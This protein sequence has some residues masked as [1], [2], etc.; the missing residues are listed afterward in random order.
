MAVE[1]GQLT[2]PAHV[3]G[4]VE[5]PEDAVALFEAGLV[6][7]AEGLPTK[8]GPRYLPGYHPTEAELEE[9]YA[10]ADRIAA[11]GGE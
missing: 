2:P 5:D 11:G 7:T 6:S 8:P 9:I 4:L 3:G 10:L 1:V